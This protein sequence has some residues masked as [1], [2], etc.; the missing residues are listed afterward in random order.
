MIS[1]ARISSHLTVCVL[2]RCRS[3]Y[4]G[5]IELIVLSLSEMSDE[6]LSKVKLGSDAEYLG[7]YKREFR[8]IHSPAPTEQ[9]R[10]GANRN[11]LS[12]MARNDVLINI[13]ADDIYMPDYVGV[14]VRELTRTD[15][16]NVLVLHFHS[17]QG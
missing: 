11:C 8:Y 5:D 1:T 13:D 3:T 17:I 9:I 14:M 7:K 6:Y 12:L 10:E 4:E 16:Q 15:I 2:Y